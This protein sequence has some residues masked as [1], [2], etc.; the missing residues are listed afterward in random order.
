MVDAG[1]PDAVFLNWRGIFAAPEVSETDQESLV[2]SFAELSET[3]QWAQALEANGWS[4]EFAGG[5]E[6]ATIVETSQ[7]DTEKL[8]NELGLVS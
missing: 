5:E 8:L 2:Q 3:E 7:A 1:Y 4:N 6:F